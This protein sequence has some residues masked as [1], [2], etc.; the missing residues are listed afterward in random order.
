[1]AELELASSEYDPLGEIPVLSVV[2]AANPSETSFSIPARW[3][4][5]I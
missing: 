1:M 5:T 2:G 4:T 3:S